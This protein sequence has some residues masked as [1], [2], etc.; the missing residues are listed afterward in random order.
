MKSITGIFICVVVALFFLS[1]SAG[2]DRTDK[3]ERYSTEFLNV[4]DTLTQLIAF[5]ENRAKFDGFAE[6]ILAEL[7]EYHCLYDIYSDY[8][9]MANL[10]TVNDNAGTAPIMVDI[11]IVDLVEFAREQHE[12]SGGKMNIAYGAVT[13]IWR[14]HCEKAAEDPASA[15]LPSYERLIEASTHTN[16]QD[17]IVDRAASTVYL[18]DPDMRLDVG[19]IAKGFAVEQTVA[20]AEKMGYTSFLINAGGDVRASGGRG[21]AKEPWVVGI[22][23]PGADGGLLATVNI[24]DMSVATS[25]DYHRSFTIDG[26]KYHHIIDTDTM[27]PSE[28]HS[29][30]T[31]VCRD[32]GL[33]DALS[34]AL[35]NMPQE[36]GEA[37]LRKVNAEA[38]WVLRDGAIKYSA[39]FLDFSANQAGYADSAG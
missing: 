16:I 27:F 7:E 37:M 22:Q 24:T 26:K 15:L 1:C 32:F 3:T 13:S 34:T 21:S 17:L 31:V 33:A 25:G 4:F 36:Q 5:A 11:R 20:R 9:G 12:L 18:R 14:E 23:D 6:F 38:M 30:V 2:A 19:A 8:E 35:F 10:K 29:S 28:Y 39:G